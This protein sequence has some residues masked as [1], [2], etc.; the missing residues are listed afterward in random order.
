MAIC[1]F[2]AYFILILWNVSREHKTSFGFLIEAVKIKL[3]FCKVQKI[4]LRVDIL[5]RNVFLLLARNLYDNY[6]SADL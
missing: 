3:G 2:A 5:L 6:K 4:S 1:S